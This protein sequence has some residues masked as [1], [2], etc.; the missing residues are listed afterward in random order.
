MILPI[1]SDGVI[2]SPKLADGRFIPILIVDTSMHRAI[3]DV[4]NL[5]DY[6][7]SGDVDSTWAIDHRD[8]FIYLLL[9]F[10]KPVS[11]EATI[12]FDILK[13]GGLVD[14]I[15]STRVFYLQPGKI[16]DRPSNSDENSRISIEVPDIS[17]RKIWFERWKKALI[18]DLRNKGLSR[19]E[20]KKASPKIIDE[21]R[22]HFCVSLKEH[23]MRCDNKHKLI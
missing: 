17:L 23:A 9:E 10:K 8:D 11:T 3:N 5:H 18:K 12:K 1:L 21:W 16:G 6:C 14:T 22:D 19:G 4:V 20:A 7:E 15:M 2:A 13:Y